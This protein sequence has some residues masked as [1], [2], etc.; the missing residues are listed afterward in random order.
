M[1]WSA[2]PV[3]KTS[4]HVLANDQNVAGTWARMAWLSGRG[5]P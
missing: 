5:V 4:R 1:P 3:W 2:M